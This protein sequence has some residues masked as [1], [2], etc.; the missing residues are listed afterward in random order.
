MKYLALIT[1]DSQV[2]GGK[3]CIRGMRVTVGTLVGLLAV[4]HSIEEI[5]QRFSIK[6]TTKKL[7][8]TVKDATMMKPIKSVFIS[9]S[10]NSH[11]NCC[12]L[13]NLIRLYLQIGLISI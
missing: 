4:G 9:N 13:I 5:L 7:P 3:P 10:I 12:R 6:P 11:S 2:M 8:Q 1:F